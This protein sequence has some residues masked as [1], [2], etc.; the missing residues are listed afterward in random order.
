MCYIVTLS[1]GARVGAWN[2]VGIPILCDAQIIE[3]YQW[4]SEGGGV[5]KRCATVI[6]CRV[7]V[8]IYLRA[9][10]CVFQYDQQK[11]FTCLKHFET[12]CYLQRQRTYGRLNTSKQ[13]AD[14]TDQRR[15]PY[16]IRAS[17]VVG[18]WATIYIPLDRP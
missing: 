10:V 6:I 11:L 12:L 4:V 2:P 7:C 18:I 14:M 9:Y 17:K 13:I 5:T 16:Q 3:C 1:V 15:M 8:V